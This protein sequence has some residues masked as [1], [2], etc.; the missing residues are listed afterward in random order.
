[1]YFTLTT[2]RACLWLGPFFASMGVQRADDLICLS[3]LQVYTSAMET[4]N[5]FWFDYRCVK[6][7]LVLPVLFFSPTSPH[8]HFLPLPAPLFRPNSRADV[9]L[10]YSIKAANGDWTWTRVNGRAHRD[11][12]TGEIDAWYCGIVPIEELIIVRLLL[13]DRG[14]Y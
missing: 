12:K 4:G 13:C 10:Y 7:F 9:V 2:Y 14:R 5:E 3:A 8:S 1:M 6:R 11:P